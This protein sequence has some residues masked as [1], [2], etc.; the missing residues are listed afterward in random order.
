MPGVPASVGRHVPVLHASHEAE[1]G[2][3]QQTPPVQK[4]EAHS[5]PAPQPCPFM[6]FAAH[7]PPW[8]NVEPRHGAPASQEPGHAPA[9]PSQP[10]LPVHAGLPSVPRGWGEQRP[11]DAARLHA[12][13]APPHAR[14]QHRPW[15]QTPASHSS[16]A[17][18]A[19]P[20]P[21]TGRHAPPRQKRPATQSEEVAHEEGQPPSASSHA[22]PLHELSG[23]VP[24]PSGRQAPA[25][26]VTSQRSHAPV[27]GPSQHTPSTQNPERQS[28]PFAHGEEFGRSSRHVPPS[29]HVAPPWHSVSAAQRVAQPATPHTYAPHAGSGAPAE[30]GRHAPVASHAWHGASHAA[31][32][33]TPSEQWPEPHSAPA[34]HGSPSARCCVQRPRL[35]WIPAG[36][37][38]PTQS[39]SVHAPSKHT[40]PAGHGVTPSQLFGRHRPF[41]HCCSEG[42]STPTQRT[43]TH[44]PSTHASP[45][46]HGAETQLRAKQLPPAQSSP[47]GHTTPMQLCETQVSLR[48]TSEGEQRLPAQR[49]G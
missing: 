47:E 36:Q 12:S 7:A 5:A 8:Q 43:S 14:S 41:A 16:A 10:R 48:Q 11:G 44:E 23:A 29:A 33:H 9:V 40:V 49:A 37:M 34:A 24:R 20:V 4:P 13:H 18:Q 17:V 26:P 27:H 42:Q 46:A 15:A 21:S 3:S 35:H 31:S 45:M 19:W 6:R 32:Q 39:T 2:P 38:T 28:E 30:S 1:H 22:R 25:L